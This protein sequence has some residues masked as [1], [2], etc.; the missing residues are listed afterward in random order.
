MNLME[1]INSRGS[2][3]PL[4]NIVGEKVAL[5]PAHKDVLP[6]LNKWENDF[7]VTFLSGDPMRPV[8]LEETVTRYERDSKGEQREQVQ[9]IIYEKATLRPIGLAE[10]RHINSRN[11]TA[12]YGI[13]IGE[14]D[15]W[16][17]GFGTETTRLMLDYGFTVLGLHNIDLTTSG[18]NQRAI[19]AYE[20][21]GFRII[22]KRREAQRWGNRV[23]H[24]VIMDCLAS[25][26]ETPLKRLL[27]LP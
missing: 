13:L 2:E 19:R 22:G 10:L 15:C 24:E 21:A 20:R 1:Q 18:Y 11:R 17:K 26:F 5:G 12:T 25:E 3:K 7:E 6:I 8:A 23:Y 14:K 4:I 16:S 27:K 9:F